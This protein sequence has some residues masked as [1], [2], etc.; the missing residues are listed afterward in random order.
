MPELNILVLNNLAERHLRAIT[1]VEPN[2]QVIISNTANAAQYIKDTDILVTWGG[3]DTQPLYLQARRLK[4]IHALSAGV[5]NLLFP[6]IQKSD[7]ILTN[8]KGIHGIPVSEHVLAMILSFTRGLNLSARYQTEQK[9]QRAPLDEIFEKTIGIIG[10]G[11]IGREIA[12]KSKALG[13]HVLAYKQQV[14]TELFVDKLY[15]ADNQNL[16]DM[17]SRSDFVVVALPLTEAT[18]ELICLEHFQ[19]MKPSAYFFNIA[20][21]SIVKEADLILALE[22]KIIQGAGLD[23]FE[24]EPLPDTSP[25]WNMPNV[26]ITPHI[27]ALSPAYLDRALKLFVDNLTRFTQGRDMLNV[28]DKAKGY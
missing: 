22:Q 28:I 25:L 2:I 10:L 5:E 12:K 27:A 26:I 6:E 4:W 18:K 7:I 17:L 3:A 13:M 24:K 8:S 19:C 16:R 23:V 15:P 14:T 9:W 21:G 11:S 1:D 20:R